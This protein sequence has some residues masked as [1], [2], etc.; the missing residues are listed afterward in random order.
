MVFM[1][2]RKW[3]REEILACFRL[4]MAMLLTEGVN[5]SNMEIAQENYHRWTIAPRRKLI[6]EGLTRGL[7]R[8]TLAEGDVVLAFEDDSPIDHMQLMAKAKLLAEARAL[9]RN[10]LRALVRMGLEDMEGGEEVVGLE[11]AQADA[12]SRS[13]PTGGNGAPDDEEDDETNGGN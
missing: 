6:A 5:R 8:G 11:A 13:R 9:T 1:E 4:P 2:G 10:E 7:L 3:S 12:R